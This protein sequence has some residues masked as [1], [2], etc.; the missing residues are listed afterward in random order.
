VNTQA[1]LRAFLPYCP[2]GLNPMTTAQL[3]SSSS[4][5]IVDDAIKQDNDSTPAG[6]PPI[7]DT[8][9]Y[10][11]SIDWVNVRQRARKGLNNVGLVVAVIGE[12]THDLGLWLSQV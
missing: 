5:K 8:V 9:N 7:D 6:F 10:V 4:T 3:Q 1:R 2:S 12:K 11:K